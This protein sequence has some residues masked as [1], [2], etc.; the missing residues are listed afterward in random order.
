VNTLH[1]VTYEFLHGFKA[2]DLVDVR[3]KQ[4]WSGPHKLLV[5]KLDPPSKG[6]TPAAWVEI[7]L[8]EEK[9]K[10]WLITATNNLFGS[11]FPKSRN[12]RSGRSE[13]SRRGDDRD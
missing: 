1:A 13:R 11:T 3:A 6:A 12:N 9:V 7:E 4:K 2:G 5:Y 8:G 10:R